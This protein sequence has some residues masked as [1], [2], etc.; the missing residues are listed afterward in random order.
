MVGQIRTVYALWDEILQTYE[1]QMDMLDM[2]ELV[3]PDAAEMQ[4]AANGIWRRVRQHRPSQRGWDLTGNETDI[5]SLG[6]PSF[7]GQPNND[8][9][10][11]R[12]DDLRN[13]IFWKESAQE[14]G[15]RMASDLNK[16]II[17]TIVNQG[18]QY[19]RSNAT[20]G[21]DFIAE[22]NVIL[23]ERQNHKSMR[24]FML[25]DRDDL[26][27]GKDLAAR[28]T[29]EG[30]PEMTWDNGGIVNPSIAGFK[31]MR[32]SFMPDLSGGANPNTTVTGAQTFAPLPGT[33]TSNNI[34]T[35]NDYRIATVPVAASASYNVG[36]KVRFDNSGTAIESI[37]LDDK[38]S[39]NQAF[40]ATIVA[41]PT[42]TSID[43]FPRPI[44][45]DD[46]AL[47][48]LQKSYSNVDTTMENLANVVRLNIDASVKTNAFW[49]KSAIEV[50]GG[51]IPAQKFKEFGGMKVMS[52]TL[53]NGLTM[54]MLYDGD[55]TTMNFTYRVFL[56]YGVTMRN[57]MNA[58]VATTFT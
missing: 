48:A 45:N 12:A 40:T 39:T 46:A 10:E 51:T 17:N 30:R 53:P 57:P 8:F 22:A 2:V 41:K 20:S 49:D 25:N 1:T 55:I 14:S 23:N 3:I 28:E 15:K 33:V 32:S 58:G 35:N 24:C 36:D 47:N 21:Y 6:Y 13:D 7:L 34:V 5:I 18:S 43:I 56:W 26:R 11:Q 16:D 9:V 31:V 42:A 27:F 44:A 29:V 19:Y 50:I 52:E 54:Y 4:N 38:T 37:G